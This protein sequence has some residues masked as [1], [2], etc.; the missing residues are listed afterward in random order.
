MYKNIIEGMNE[1]KMN[2]DKA[3]VQHKAVIQHSY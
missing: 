2:T 1:Y 3:R